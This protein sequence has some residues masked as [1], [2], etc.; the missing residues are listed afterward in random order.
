MSQIFKKKTLKILI[1]DVL[2]I[3]AVQKAPVLY[4]CFILWNVLFVPREKTVIHLYQE[5]K[6]IICNCKILHLN[7][8][9]SKALT[10]FFF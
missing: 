1:L 7:E 5:D 10:K 9:N 8:I 2:I 3:C 4:M 6:G